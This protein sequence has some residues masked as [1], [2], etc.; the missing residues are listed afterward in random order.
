MSTLPPSSTLELAKPPPD[1]REGGFTLPANRGFSLVVREADALSEHVWAWQDLAAAALEPNVFCEPWFLLPALKA[2]PAAGLGLSFVFV[3]GP[4]ESARNPPVLHGFFPLGRTRLHRLLPLGVLRLWKHRYSFLS[5]P[6]IR[7]ERPEECLS[8][9]LDWLRADRQGASLWRLEEIASEGPFARLLA[10]VCAERHRPVFVVETWE[11]RLF[12]PR[13]D[14]EAYLGEALS[15]KRLKEV[16]RK[17][18][19]LRKRGRLERRIL[20]PGGDAGAWAEQFLRLEASGWKGRAGTAMACREADAA[21]FREAVRGAFARGQLLLIGLFLDG[22]PVALKCHLLANGGAFAFKIA[23]DESVAAHSPGV[24]LELAA[25]EH[26]HQNRVA[27]WVDSCAA[28]RSMFDRL[29]LDRRGLQTLLIATGRPPGDL[30]VSLAPLAR[31]L[32]RKL[33]RPAPTRADERG[34]LAARRE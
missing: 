13:A 2:A 8:A 33:R 29:W 28:R 4:A 6:L 24:L 19:A 18:R 5:T 15:R 21:F 3:Y 27:P 9:F 12:L 17:E 11:R 23:Y 14:A 16:R 31:W 20:G 22:R 7:A 34:N 1:A 32:A 25:L 10:R 30:I 26:L